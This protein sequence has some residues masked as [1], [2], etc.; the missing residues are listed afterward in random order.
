MI[1]GV[2]HIAVAIFGSSK[3]LVCPLN[4]KVILVLL[5]LSFSAGSSALLLGLITSP[6]YNSFR[7]TE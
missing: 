4:Y 7:I 5:V 3:E 2:Y 1:G 6:P